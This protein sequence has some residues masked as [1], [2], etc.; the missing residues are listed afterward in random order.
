MDTRGDLE[1]TSLHWACRKGYADIVEILLAHGASLTIEDEQVHGTSPA[2]FG[3]GVRNCH[4][5]NGD[6]PQ[7]R[8][9][10]PA[11]DLEPLMNADKR[12]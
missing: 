7:V 11:E 3:H 9:A 5:P 6:Y 1:G 10:I 4:E 8:A 2:W 12:G